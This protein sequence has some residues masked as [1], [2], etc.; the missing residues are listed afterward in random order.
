MLWNK[1]TLFKYPLRVSLEISAFHKFPVLRTY[2]Q[3][4]R[5]KVMLH[6]AGFQY[7][8]VGTRY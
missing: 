6:F 3:S 5:L 4:D 7:E 1:S 8:W 2:R